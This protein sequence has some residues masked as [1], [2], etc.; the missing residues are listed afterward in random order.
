MT[1]AVCT[2]SCLDLADFSGDLRGDGRIDPE[3]LFAH[4]RFTGEFEEHAAVDGIGHIRRIISELHTVPARR[5][6]PAVRDACPVRPALEL[7]GVSPS[8]KRTNRGD[9]DVL[10]HLRD[11]RLHDLADRH[12][13]IANR[14]LIEQADL[15][16]EAVQLALDDLLDDLWPA[17]SGLP[18]APR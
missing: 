12:L 18:S 13:R 8:L 9:G 3:R 2:P 15:L 5:P 17:C 1:T 11:R 7:R 4:E 16:V 10:A 6:F 14:R